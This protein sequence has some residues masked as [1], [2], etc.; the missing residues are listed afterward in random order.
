MFHTVEARLSTGSN[1]S[2]YGTALV[3]IFI[4]DL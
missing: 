2:G 1:W 3:V 4:H